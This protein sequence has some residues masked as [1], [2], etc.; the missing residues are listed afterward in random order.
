M[1]DVDSKT[2]EKWSYLVTL[3]DR[4]TRD[5]SISWD[6]SS[7]QDSFI[8]NI[9]EDVIKITRL[10]AGLNDSAD[11]IVIYINDDFGNLIDSFSDED[12]TTSHF[13]SP[14]TFLSDLHKTIA[15][16]VRGADQALDRIIKRLAEKEDD[17]FAGL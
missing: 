16:R 6:E 13:Q 1:T 14:Y 10:S 5:N 7:D 9:G 17:P 11:L 2:L 15:R 4:L 8:T 3:L 12:L